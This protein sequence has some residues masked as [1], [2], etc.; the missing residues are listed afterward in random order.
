MSGRLKGFLIGLA[1][2]FS[3]FLCCGAGYWLWSSLGT[4][5][6]QWLLGALAL[7]TG[8][9]VIGIIISLVVLVG[10]VALVMWAQNQ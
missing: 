8:Y 4:V 1:G 7:V 3:I 9:Y 2:F 6:Q 10:L 5:V